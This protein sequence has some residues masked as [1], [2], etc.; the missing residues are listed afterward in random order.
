[1]H[2]WASSVSRLQLVI[3]FVKLCQMLP[4]VRSLRPN[5]EFVI[6]E[7]FFKGEIVIHVLISSGE[8]VVNLNNI[9]MSSLIFVRH[10]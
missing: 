9:Y 5:K 10:D 8:Q 4:I 3:K 7:D 2:L 6:L 1:M